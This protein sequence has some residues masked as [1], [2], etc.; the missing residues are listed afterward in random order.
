MSCILRVF[1]SYYFGLENMILIKALEIAFKS[2]GQNL[3]SC[4]TFSTYGVGNQR[5]KTS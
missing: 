1:L 5:N 4:F 3:N 2:H